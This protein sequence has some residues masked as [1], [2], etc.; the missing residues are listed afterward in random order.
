MK[1]IRGRAWAVM[2]LAGAVVLLMGLF[3]YLFFT[4]GGS[5]VSFP[6]NGDAF[7]SGRLRAGRVT[8]RNGETLYAIA[9][10]EGAYGG[11]E[12][13]RRALLHTLGDKNG[14]I[15]TGALYKYGDRILGW[16]PV[17]GVYDPRGDGGELVLS[18]DARVCRAALQALDGRSG[19]VFLM[20]YVTGE[21]LCA[22]SSPTFDPEDPP[23]LAWD[24][25]S[26]VYLNRALSVTYP[27][28]STFKLVTLAAAV[29]RIDDLFDRDFTCAGS[30]EIGGG[31][32][33][34][35]KAHGDMKIE[36]AFANSCNCVFA[37]LAVELGG[38]ILREYAARY[39]LLDR[40]QVGKSLTAAGRYD[41]AGP[42]TLDLGWSGA[43]QY[44][45]L[46]CPA[47]M[48]RLAAAIANG[49]LAPEMTDLRRD[50]DA[51]LTRIMEAETA[52]RL[53]EMMDYAVAHT[54]GDKNFPGL[55][56]RAKSGTAEV[57]ADRPHAWFVGYNADP[58]APYA[59]AVCVENAGSGASNA[60]PVARAIL[61][62][63]A[64]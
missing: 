31:T 62:A 59:F 30:V 36:D 41:V 3:L 11:D 24:D 1:K 34:C 29:E 32:V 5:W 19:A 50:G 48:A 6:A 13:T 33:T 38:D 12:L 37:A 45:D 21:V 2:A 61:Q 51:P 60:G 53:G 43:G 23:N 20:N 39:G 10:G 18:A 42:G 4:R 54:Y 64:G 52:R 63:A 7:I 40:L 17:N 49:G 35:S 57:G 22:V 14:N 46:V 9:D 55:D 15:G 8:D 27:P 28:G 25:T 56:L 26:G 44:N 16:D 58:Q 47:A